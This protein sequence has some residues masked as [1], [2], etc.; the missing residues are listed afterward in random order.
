[1]SWLS[2]RICPRTV[3]HA[4]STVVERLYGAYEVEFSDDDGRTYA[5]LAFSARSE[6]PF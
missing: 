6:R 1:M 4:G 5:E 2:S 3:S